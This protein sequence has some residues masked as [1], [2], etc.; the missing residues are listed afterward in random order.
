MILIYLTNMETEHKIYKGQRIE[1]DN[2]VTGRN[3]L[4]IYYRSE[5]APSYSQINIIQKPRDPGNYKSEA[6]KISCE[7]TDFDSLDEI[8]YNELP[9]SIRK[10]IDFIDS[11]WKTR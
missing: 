3:Y 4:A 2:R 10:Q 8:D 1:T 9:L 5:Y 7:L 6:V 11:Y